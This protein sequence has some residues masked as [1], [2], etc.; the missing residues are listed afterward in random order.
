LGGVG[1]L[2]TLRV[3]VGCFCPTA[4]A[5]LD[6]FLHHTPKLG[7]TVE[8]EQFLLKLFLRRPFPL[9]LT[10]K[11]HSLCV[12]GSEILESRSLIFYLRL[13]NPGKNLNRR[14]AYVFEENLVSSA[15]RWLIKGWLLITEGNIYAENPPGKSLL[16]WKG[17]GRTEVGWRPGQ[18]ASLAPP[19][20]N[21]WSFG[22]KCAPEE[23]TCDI[24][25]T[26]RRP[27]NC[28][29]LVTPLLWG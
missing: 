27:G 5:Q 15:V 26:F 14:R 17:G 20:S 25:G 4:D 7:I 2:T 19:Y 3:A 13:S 11:F 22:S 9:I 24:F 8:M 16:D 21:L 18:E 23:S 6:H 10:T 1:F 28:A 12:K 29:P